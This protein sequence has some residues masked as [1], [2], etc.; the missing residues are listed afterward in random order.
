M[1]TT[2]TPA[3]GDPAP[4]FTLPASGAARVSLADHAGRPVVLFFYP[5]DDTSGCTKEALAF[6]ASADA[7][8]AADAALFGV[9]KD[10]VERHDAFIAKHGLNL[11]LLS[12]AESDV[13]ERYGVWTQKSMY[14]RKF[15]GIERSTFL[16]GRDGRVVQAWRKVKVPGHAEVVLAALDGI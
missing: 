8:A 5:K 15:M 12:D 1:T 2:T 11:V 9:S 7:F 10:T 6:S 4:A 13:C 3:V 16:I 14:G